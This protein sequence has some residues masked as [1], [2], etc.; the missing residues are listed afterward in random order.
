MTQLT[1]PAPG[2]RMG[3]SGIKPACQTRLEKRGVCAFAGT[4]RTCPWYPFKRQ[5]QLAKAPPGC[6]RIFNTSWSPRPPTVSIRG[7]WQPVAMPAAFGAGR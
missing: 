3:D 4:S 1:G 6:V 2:R 7:R 5:R